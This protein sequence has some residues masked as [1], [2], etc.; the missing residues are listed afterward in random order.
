[1]CSYLICVWSIHLENKMRSR[2][3]QLQESITLNT[4]IE[5]TQTELEKKYI[6]LKS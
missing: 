3:K 2:D 4:E 5:T 6:W 1:M